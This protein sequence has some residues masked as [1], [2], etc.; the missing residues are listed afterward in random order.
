VLAARAPDRLRATCLRPARASNEAALL[1]RLAAS[2]PATC[3]SQLAVVVLATSVSRHGSCGLAVIVTRQL[4]LDASPALRRKFLR[5]V[6]SVS[7]QP[8]R[9][10]LWAVADC[11]T[12]HALEVLMNVAHHRL[13][14]NWNSSARLGSSPLARLCPAIGRSGS[15]SLR[16]ADAGRRLASSCR[17]SACCRSNRTSA[18]PKNGSPAR[19]APSVGS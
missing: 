3:S 10:S 11:W 7:V 18:R 6:L 2:W 15:R 19:S 16:L 1:R 4:R 17:R 14:G 9:L 8:A 12:Q 13:D 5:L